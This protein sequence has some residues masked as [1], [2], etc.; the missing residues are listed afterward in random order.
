MK[1]S[2]SN[3][4]SFCL[5]SVTEECLDSCRSK[6]ARVDGNDASVG[7]GAVSFLIDPVAFPPNL[8]FDIL[9]SNIDEIPHRV[10]LAGG[11]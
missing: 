8:Y 2:V 3:P 11:Y 6:I 5:G 7:L 1:F 9:G 4:R 10:L